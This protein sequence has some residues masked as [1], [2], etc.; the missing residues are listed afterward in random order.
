MSSLAGFTGSPGIAV[1]GASKG[2][3]LVLGEALWHELGASGVSVLACCAGAVRTPSYIRSGRGRAPGLLEPAA[4]AEETLRAL[5]HGPL[6]I[7]G[8]FNR[9]AS[10]FLRRLLPR[11]AAIAIMASQSAKPT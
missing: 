9:F 3:N 8:R 6:V 5:G 10:I 7:P 4:V 2:F 1:Y 11:R